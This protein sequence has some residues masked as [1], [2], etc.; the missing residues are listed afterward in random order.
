MSYEWRY[1]NEAK[2]GYLRLNEGEV[3]KTVV[4]VDGKVMLDKDKD[5][6]LLGIEILV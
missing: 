3:A 4:L 2:A 6:N 1:D 5:G